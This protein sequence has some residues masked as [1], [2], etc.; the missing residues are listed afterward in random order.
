MTFVAFDVAA[1]VVLVRAVLGADDLL[2][3]NLEIQKV[4]H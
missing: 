1:D 4:S 2:L 3:R